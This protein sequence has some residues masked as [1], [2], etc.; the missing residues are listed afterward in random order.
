V[1]P[2]SRR[3]FR[4]QNR[5]DR[6]DRTPGPARRRNLPAEFPRRRVEPRIRARNR[7]RCGNLGPAALHRARDLPTGDPGPEPDPAGSRRAAVR[8]RSRSRLRCD[9]NDVVRD[10]E[11]RRRPR[12]RNRSYS[13]TVSTA[14]Q[15]RARPGE[16]EIGGGCRCDR[17]RLSGGADLGIPDRRRPD[18]DVVPVIRRR[19]RDRIECASCDLLLPR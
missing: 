2:A 5:L 1:P 15:R 11:L 8:R 13:G 9:R 18:R 19:S 4:E 16:I 14:I 12:R 10:P 7:A 17:E 3:E 6:L